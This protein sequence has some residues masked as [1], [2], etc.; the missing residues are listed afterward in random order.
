MSKK[1]RLAKHN[2]QMLEHFDAIYA[3]EKKKIVFGGGNPGASIVL[4][5]EAPGEQEALQGKPFVGK[6][7]KVLDEFLEKTGIR[8]EDL[9]I[10]N[11]VKLRPTA[12]SKA[13]RTVNRAPSREEIALFR[14]W[15][16]KEMEIIRPKYIVTLGNVA[17]KAVS[18]N[19][20]AVIG[21][22]HG[23]LYPGGAMGAQLFPLY[24]PAALIYNR[25][26]R[27]VYQEDLD[28]LGGLIRE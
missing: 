23:K 19:K 13:G 8:R 2:A 5:G 26:L 11:V 16:Q 4:I 24:H 9:Y 10:S 22:L 12:I 18:D 14:P 7:G 6:A 15:L 21:E 25:S 17:L 3:P 20:S 27:E 28:S 1:Q